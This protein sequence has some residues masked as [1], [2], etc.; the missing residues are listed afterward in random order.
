MERKKQ[1]DVFFPKVKVLRTTIS[2]LV[3]FCLKGQIDIDGLWMPR[4]SWENPCHKKLAS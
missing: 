4:T 2:Y 1:V 3:S